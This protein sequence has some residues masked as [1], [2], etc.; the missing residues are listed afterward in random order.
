MAAKLSVVQ[1][2]IKKLTE[3]LVSP[4][5]ATK[6]PD[7]PV[8]LEHAQLTRRRLLRLGGTLIALCVVKPPGSKFFSFPPL[9]YG[10]YV[11]ETYRY[12][13]FSGY[14]IVGYFPP[15]DSPLGPWDIRLNICG[16]TYAE[17]YDEVKKLLRGAAPGEDI[18]LG[19]YVYGGRGKLLSTA[20][21]A[22]MR[23]RRGMP[24]VEPLGKPAIVYQPTLQ[25]LPKIEIGT[26]DVVDE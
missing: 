23:K 6:D 18:A 22:K 12:G 9:Q 24:G 19:R 2:S 1:W 25:K 26:A 11:D 20:W 10:G 5:L 7:G 4:E 3:Y 17:A 21:V 13:I 14:P 15:N 16:K 8:Q